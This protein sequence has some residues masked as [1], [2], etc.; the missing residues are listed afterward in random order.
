MQYTGFTEGDSFSN[1]VQ[2]NLDMLGALVL[3][4]VG[5]EVDST[6]VVTIDNCG[7]PKRAAKFLQKMAQP[8]GLSDSICNGAIF[9]LCTGPGHCGLALGRPGHEVVPEKHCITRC[10]FAGVRTACPISIR[11]DSKISR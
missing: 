5:G 9:S 8:A 11:V 2:V 4:G 7:A 6:D 3:D 1:E 10:G